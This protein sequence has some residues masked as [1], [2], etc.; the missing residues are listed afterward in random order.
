MGLLKFDTGACR[1]V[2]VHKLLSTQKDYDKYHW[3]SVQVRTGSHNI[4]NGKSR[5]IATVNFAV[6][7][8]IK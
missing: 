8:K 2:D 6:R 4:T 3:F 1:L 7:L 5:Y